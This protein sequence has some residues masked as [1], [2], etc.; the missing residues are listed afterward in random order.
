MEG[1]P[2]D[3]AEED[4]SMNFGWTSRIPR[5]RGIEAETTQI[6]TELRNAYHVDG[7]EDIRVIR[8]RQTSKCTETHEDRF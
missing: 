4:V 2:V 1:L 5:H 6:S 3:M 8:D 7:L